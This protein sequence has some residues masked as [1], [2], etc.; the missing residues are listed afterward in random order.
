MTQDTALLR[1]QNRTDQLARL[2]FPGGR[3]LPSSVSSGG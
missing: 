3:P 2:M 1:L